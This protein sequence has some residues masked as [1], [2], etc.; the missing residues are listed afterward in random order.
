MP[1]F[2]IFRQKHDLFIPLVWLLR[3]AIPVLLVVVMYFVDRLYLLQHQE[4]Q[5]ED[6]SQ[7]MTKLKWQLESQILQNIQ[8]VQGLTASI[9][10]E[11]DMNQQRFAELAQIILQGGPQLR[12]VGAAPDLIMQLIYPLEGNEEVLGLDFRDLA[13]QWPG[14]KRAVESGEMVFAGPVNLVQGGQGLVGRIPVYT[15]KTGELWGV[16]SAVIDMDALYQSVG[17]EDVED[18]R[19]RLA[20]EDAFGQPGEI[21]WGDK[22]SQWQKP[23]INRIYIPG[24]NWLMMSMPAQRWSRQAPETPWLR[25]ALIVLWLVLSA[26]VFWPTRLMLRE[27]QTQQRFQA[28]FRFSPIGMALKDCQDDRLVAVNPAMAAMLEYE[29]AALLGRQEQELQVGEPTP[30]KNKQRQR[31]F[32]RQGYSGP[33]ERQYLNRW[34]QPVDSKCYELLIDEGS[35]RKLVW[36][37]AEDVSHQKRTE[38][39]QQEFI[40]TVSHELRTPLTSIAG[41][42]GLIASGKL[43]ELPEKAQ[44][45]INI[46]MRNTQ[47]LHLL[48]NDL[49]DLEKLSTGNMLMDIRPICLKTLIKESTESLQHYGQDKGI[50]VQLNELSDDY[51]MADEQKLKQAL[52]NLLSN[53]IKFSPRDGKVEVCTEQSGQNI[54]VIV[55]DYGAGIPKQFQS[56]IFNR[57]A[58][59]DSSDS[60]TKSGTGLGLA[61]TKE[62]MEKMNGGVGFDSEPGQGARFWLDIPLTGETTG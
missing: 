39:M 40:A 7:K 17:L 2:N 54:R 19:L 36:L 14:V 57:F 59:A 45:L 5:R 51:V 20:R 8:V 10:T 21:F 42:L 37:V 3:I 49:L 29:P 41:S 6:V 26:A 9:A 48:I 46:A 53:A 47:H 38:R 12:N 4:Q 1:Q 35:K 34:Q 24:N 30:K 11:P 33:F 61:I 28:L 27:R 62:L 56:R 31:D 55:R 52:K 50:S 32:S 43:G 13:E 15:Q 22:E 58:Q 25:G 44:N 18:L 23:V 60:R 16:I